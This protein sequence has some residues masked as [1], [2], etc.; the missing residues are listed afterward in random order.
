MPHC[1][2]RERH[3]LMGVYHEHM[4]TPLGQAPA[5]RTHVGIGMLI[6]IQ[7]ADWWF[8]VMG[9]LQ[10]RKAIF[11]VCLNLVWPRSGHGKE[12]NHDFAFWKVAYNKNIPTSSVSLGKKKQSRLQYR[13]TVLWQFKTS[14]WHS[15]NPGTSDLCPA[16]LLNY[17]SL[18]GLGFWRSFF[19]VKQ[20]NPGSLK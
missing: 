3:W 11:W 20:L 15:I 7:C 10:N 16:Y 19:K 12:K 8:A 9:F 13:F 6:Q 2:H 5:G 14:K 17:S 1:T 18:F 4:L